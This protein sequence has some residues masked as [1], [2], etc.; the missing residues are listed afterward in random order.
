MK[1]SKQSKGRTKKY[2]YPERTQEHLDVRGNFNLQNGKKDKMLNIHSE[3]LQKQ[4]RFILT[5]GDRHKDGALLYFAWIR[6]QE[7]KSV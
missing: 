5:S 3:T 4:R 6:K 7:L 2:I 1:D